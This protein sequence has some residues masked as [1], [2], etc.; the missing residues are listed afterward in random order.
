MSLLKKTLTAFLFVLFSI[1]V[2]AE[3]HNI[4]VQCGL[5][6]FYKGTYNFPNKLDSL[7][8]KD[9]KFLIKDEADFM[10]ELV[11]QKYFADKLEGTCYAKTY[12]FTGNKYRLNEF[13]CKEA[14]DYPEDDNS[15]IIVRFTKRFVNRETNFSINLGSD[16]YFEF[17]RHGNITEKKEFSFN[18]PRRIS[19][20]QT[21]SYTNGYVGS[22]RIC[23]LK[24][25]L[26]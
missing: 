8:I 24:V 26:P 9:S 17:T 6:T 19:F 16:D 3:N 25:I 12:I 23:S 2:N 21:L 13:D 14:W 7:I 18:L 10:V 20:V 1:L 4:N 22:R 5:D 11:G 15:N